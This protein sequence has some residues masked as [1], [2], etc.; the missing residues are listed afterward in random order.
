LHNNPLR[1]FVISIIHPGILQ[2]IFSWASA[3]QREKGI[4]AYREAERFQ[5]S[6]EEKASRV[7][8][9]YV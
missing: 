3:Y 7:L 1:A 4:A 8:D 6:G 2:S 5:T 9:I